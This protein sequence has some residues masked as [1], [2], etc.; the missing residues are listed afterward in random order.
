[1]HR[2]LIAVV[3]AVAAAVLPMGAIALA[4]CGATTTGKG[5]MPTPSTS[6]AGF[7][8]PVYA[9]NFPDPQIVADGAGYLALSTNGNGMNVQTLTSQDMVTWVQ[10]VDAL[11]HV[12][13]W[14]TAGKVWA[15]ETMRWADGSYRLYYTTMAPDPQWQCISAAS[16]ATVRGPY[17]DVSTKPLVC[18]TAEGGSIDQS[19]FIAAD[20]TAYLLWKNDGN[21]AG[22]DTWLR[23]ARLSADG[24]SLAGPITN[25]FKQ[26]LPWEGHLV[27]APAMVEIDGIFHLFYSANDY[28]SADYAVGHATA[29]SVLGPYIKD[30]EPVLHTNAVAAGP[31][32]C[33]LIKVGTQ[34][35]MVYHAWAPNAVGDETTGRQM[36]LSRVT[37]DGT[38][39]AV[40]QPA[41]RVPVRP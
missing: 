15:P 6:A 40:E 1:M 17:T 11:P 13:T 35:W 39:V 21:A 28:G 37:F 26:T 20:G 4:G 3:A 10:G 34:W 36:W 5:A 33:Q 14:S 32:H 2:R 31:G 16:A 8:N 19:P 29:T 23:A 24:R 30:P 9:Q 7:A 12:A 38:K 22:V 41:A 27:E 25:L 18:E